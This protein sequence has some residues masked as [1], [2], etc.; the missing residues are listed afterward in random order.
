MDRELTAHED[1]ATTLH[2]HF[3]AHLAPH[4]SR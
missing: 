2:T 1:K 4:P 3:F